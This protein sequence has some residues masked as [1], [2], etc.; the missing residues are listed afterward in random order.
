MGWRVLPLKPGR[1]TRYEEVRSLPSASSPSAQALAVGTADTER[2]L[3]VGVSLPAPSHPRC[4]WRSG[5]R[6]PCPGAHAH[7]RAGRMCLP[8]EHRLAHLG[9]RGFRPTAATAVSGRSRHRDGNKDAGLGTAAV[10][11]TRTKQPGGEG[12]ERG[13]RGWGGADLVPQVGKAPG[14]WQGKRAPAET[15]AAAGKINKGERAESWAGSEGER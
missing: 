12:R 6:Y 10:T 15:A 9:G 1:G 13:R 7:A 4:L 8:V 2:Y 14:G 11:V 5:G 3:R